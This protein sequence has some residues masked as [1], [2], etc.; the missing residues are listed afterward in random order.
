M[1]TR[2]PSAVVVVRFHWV[3]TKYLVLLPCQAHS[4]HSTYSLSSEWA[5]FRSLK[6]SQNEFHICLAWTQNEKQKRLLLTLWVGYHSSILILFNKKRASWM[7]WER[8]ATWQKVTEHKIHFITWRVSVPQMCT[9]MWSSIEITSLQALP[10]NSSQ[11]LVEKWFS[12][13]SCTEVQPMIK[14]IPTV[15]RW[16]EL[17][18]RNDQHCIFSQGTRPGVT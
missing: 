12:A 11:F 7:W 13:K 10:G 18:R 16:K 14:A 2:V 1:G 15:P 5:H 9:Q 8:Q 17:E 4:R 3:D 6:K